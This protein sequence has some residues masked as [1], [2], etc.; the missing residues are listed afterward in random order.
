[1]ISLAQV[2]RGQTVRICAI[3]AADVRGQ[4][5]RLGLGVG[6]IATCAAVI[7]RGP[8]VLSKARQE[9]AV[10]RPIAEAI[11]VEVLPA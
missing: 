9:I 4:A 1:L 3:D 8:I 2:T 5:L 11:Q 7:P 10:G 6:A